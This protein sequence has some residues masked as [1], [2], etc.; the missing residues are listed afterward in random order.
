MKIHYG[1]AVC[2]AVWMLALAARAG[3]GDL[4][5]SCQP[6]KIEDKV[7]AQK[8]DEV[9]KTQ[10]WGYSITVENKTFKPLDDLEVKYIIFYRHEYLGIKG[11]PQKKQA[12]GSYTIKEVASNDKVTFD[13]DPVELTKASLLGPVG[14]YSYFT[15]G[16]KPSAED[17]LTGIWIRIYQNGNLFTEFAKPSDLTDREKWE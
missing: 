17:S 16:A 7:T 8:S 15:N 3:D 13:T 4:D 5:V 11:P 1:H 6:K 9:S 14:G 2:V 10:K 12:S